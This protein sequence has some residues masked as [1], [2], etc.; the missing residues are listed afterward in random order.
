MK[1]ISFIRVLLSLLFCYILCWQPVALASLDNQPEI[2][3]LH[4]YSPDYEW[5]QTEQAGLDE[6]FKPLIHKY[7]MRIEYMDSNNNPELQLPLLKQ[8]YKVK[9]ANSHFKTIIA[10]D[11]AALNFLRLYRDELFPGV[12]VV[13]C[14]INGYEDSLLNGFSDF[15]GIA[16]DN[17]FLGLFNVIQTLHPNTKRI[18]IYGIPTDPSHIANAALIKKLLPDLHKD[19][20]VE[21]R[22]FPHLDACIEDAQQLPVADSIVIMVGSMHTANGE[23]VNLQRANELM[24]Q[25]V[26]IP[27]YTAW[28]FA[29]GHGAVGGLVI[30]GEEQGRIAGKIALKILNGISPREIS[31]SRYAANVYMFDYNQLVRFGLKTSLLPLKSIMINSP[32]TTYTIN[33]GFFWAVIGSLLFLFL[34]I[35]ALI[36]TIR[37]RKKMEAALLSSEEKF[38]KAFKYCADIIGIAALDDGRYIEVSETFFDTFGYT[39]EEVIGKKSISQEQRNPING[40]FPLWLNGEERVN[41][42]Q[43]LKSDRLFKNLETQWCTK[44]GEIRIGLYSAEVVEIGGESCIIYAWHDITKRK[45]A[46]KALQHAYDQLEYQVEQRTHELTSLNQELIAMNEELESINWELGNEITERRRVEAELSNANQKLNE[47]I[48]ELKTMQDFLVESAKM[49]AL[50][51]L[52]AGIAHEINT[53]IG[54]SLT[55]A[56][57]LRELSQEFDDLCN[58]GTPRRIDMA[59][60]LQDLHEASTIILKNLERAGKLIHSFK[61][62]SSDQSSEFERVFNVKAYLEEILYSL[63]PKFKNTNHHITIEC[64]ELLTI[65]GLPGAFSQVLTNLIMNSL[66]H[67]Y[68]PTDEGHIYICVRVEHRTIVFLYSDDGKGMDAQVLS[69]IFDPFYTTKRGYGG[70]GLGLYL[71]YNIVTQQFKGNITCESQLGEGTTFKIT[72]PLPKEDLSS[73]AHE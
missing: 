61:Q 48:D 40:D 44:S 53:P 58:N 4:S 23:G 12:P 50:G 15:T 9:F 26:Q 14:G 7:K 10:S 57:H 3:I 34:A 16:E 24:S 31:V 51:N 42:F 72:I 73:G 18:V 29:L 35:F 55:A 70:T 45:H 5:T 6:V 37:Q 69:K 28:D 54:I 62:V 56:S 71:I 46:E 13:F 41:L 25:A 27:I 1:I 33:R 52:V 2:L 8:L 36:N 65:Q 17:D 43:K 30:S 68:D 49:A 20:Q 66:N 11:N 38:S 64:S 67:G 39:R 21:I 59:T 22:E 19:Y 63:Q 32:E 47:A 60:Y